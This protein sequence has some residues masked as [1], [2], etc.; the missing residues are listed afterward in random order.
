MV[1]AEE[2]QGNVRLVAD[3]PAVVSG[4]DVDDISRR[5]SVTV[6]LS[7]AAVAHPETTMPTCSTKQL[8]A[9]VAGPTCNDHLQPGS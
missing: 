2:M 7:I 4:C 6:P 5:N 1:R 8:D 9:P 3:H